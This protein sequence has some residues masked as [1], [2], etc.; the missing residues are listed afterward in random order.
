MIL[1]TDEL[2]K[3][4]MLNCEKNTKYESTERLKGGWKERTDDDGQVQ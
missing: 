3:N 1:I 4:K 2:K